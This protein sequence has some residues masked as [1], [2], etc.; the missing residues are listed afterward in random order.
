M[1]EMNVVYVA[2]KGMYGENGMTAREAASAD[3]ILVKCLHEAQVEAENLPIRRGWQD[4]SV[5][6]RTT[7]LHLQ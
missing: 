7:S 3:K 2:W 4:G 5:R 1:P 6:L